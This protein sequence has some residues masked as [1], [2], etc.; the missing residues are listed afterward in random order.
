MVCDT[1]PLSSF[2]IL[3]PS[4]V[5][6]CLFYCLYLNT[7]DLRFCFVGIFGDGKSSQ[8]ETKSLDDMLQLFPAV[9]RVRVGTSGEKK[10][11]FTLLLPIDFLVG[12]K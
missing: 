7:F 6:F 8:K 9:C 2:G 12:L 1:S 5:Y 11:V 4:Y 3:D 10:M